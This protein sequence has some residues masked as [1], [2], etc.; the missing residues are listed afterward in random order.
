MQIEIK[1]ALKRLQNQEN[2]YKKRPSASFITT[3]GFGKNITNI[4]VLLWV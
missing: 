2:E 1:R 3:R 4:L